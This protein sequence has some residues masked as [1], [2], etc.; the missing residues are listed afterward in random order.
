MRVPTCGFF[1]LI[2]NLIEGNPEC[3]QVRPTNDHNQNALKEG[4]GFLQPSRKK[5]FFAGLP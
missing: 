1:P 2:L 3:C 4:N 5:V